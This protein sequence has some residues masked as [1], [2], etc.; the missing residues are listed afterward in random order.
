MEQIES[1]RHLYLCRVRCNIGTD[2]IC[3]PTLLSFTFKA[4]W[5]GSLR[6]DMSRPAASVVLA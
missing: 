6:T 2:D 1:V 5:Y 4:T 3:L